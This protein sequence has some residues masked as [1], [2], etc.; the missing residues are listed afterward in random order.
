M[1]KAEKTC[2]YHTTSRG[3]VWPPARTNAE[4]SFARERPQG[5][6]PDLCELVE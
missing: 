1:I 5:T 6:D 3:R 4:V 2:E